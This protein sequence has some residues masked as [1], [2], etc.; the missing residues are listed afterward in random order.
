MLEV[1]N[2]FVISA[3]PA[4][5]KRGKARTIDIFGKI[6]SIENKLQTIKM[7]DSSN[8]T[9]LNFA[10]IDFNSLPKQFILNDDFI[11][12]VPEKLQTS[13]KPIDNLSTRKIAPIQTISVHEDILSCPSGDTDSTATDAVRPINIVPPLEN[14]FLPRGKPHAEKYISHLAA[15]SAKY[16]KP[17]QLWVSAFK[18]RPR[19]LTDFDEIKLLGEGHFSIVSCVRHR[20]DGSLYALKKLKERISSQKQYLL[21]MREVNALSVLNGCEFILQYYGCW[22]YDDH[23]YIQTELCHL[24]SLED[25]ITSFPSPFSVMVRANLSALEG[26]PELDTAANEGALKMSISNSSLCRSRS[27]ENS[28]YASLEREKPASTISSNNVCRGISEDVAWLCLQDLCTALDFMHNK[29]MVH[30]DLRPANFFLTTSVDCNE[31]RYQFADF[32]SPSLEH[33]FIRSAVEERIVQRQYLVKLGDFGHCSRS[34][35]PGLI[36]EGE[37]RYF[38]RELF[39]HD[40]S[41]L[42]LTKADMFSLG[43]S[44]YELCLGKFLSLSEPTLAADSSAAAALRIPSDN[45]WSIGEERT[46]EL[47]GGE[48]EF[49]AGMNFESD[50]SSEWQ[51]LRNGVL[52]ESVVSNYSS[53]LVQVLRLLLHPDPSR[54]PSAYHCK[55]QLLRDNYVGAKGRIIFRNVLSSTST[56]GNPELDSIVDKDQTIRTLLAE[57]AELKQKLSA[58][59]PDQLE[60]IP[61]TVGFELLSL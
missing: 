50:C 21:M 26:G 28:L 7:T 59:K 51:R 24:G 53:N 39:N 45:F 55:S 20:L 29:G 19:E 57:N 9:N 5:K 27:S 40:S 4:R 36:I 30:M 43:A 34:D 41:R 13:T 38:A 60:R 42:D 18:E 58:A 47:K 25:L 14:Y 1:L 48:E 6:E 52:N 49:P 12:T 16:R 23:L 17:A 15:F 61:V 32:S 22:V 35:E 31:D 11:P 2:P 8:K 44:I 33:E 54:R 3:S 10:D 56:T 46:C 37:N